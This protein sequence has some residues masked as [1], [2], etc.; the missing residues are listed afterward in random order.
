MQLQLP[1]INFITTDV[2]E[3]VNDSIKMYESLSGRKLGEAD[4]MRLILL[5]HAYIIVQQNIKINEAARQNLLYYATGNVLE[6]KGTEWAT[7]KL[8]ATAA[9]TILRV[10]FPQ[11]LKTA[12]IIVKGTLVTAD[13]SLFFETIE[14]TTCPVDAVSID[15]PIR[16]TQTG[17]IGNG[18]NEGMI[19]TLVKPLSFVEKVENIAVSSGGAEEE[20]DDE[21]RARIYQ[22]PEQ[23]SVAGPTG[24][25]EYHAKKA[26][27]LIADVKV[28]SPEPGV[29]NVSVIEEGGRLPSEAVLEAVTA[30]LNV[31]SVRPLT[32]FVVVKAPEQKEY[33]LDVT[34][35]IDVL[36]ND[37][38]L[39]QQKIEKA[40]D[41]Y[42]VWQSS[43]IGRDINP[44]QL[45]AN[46]IAAG[47]KRVDVLSPS[48]AAVT[49]DEV[50]VLTTRNV[51]FG[52]EE[53]A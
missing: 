38:T 29:V 6:H 49:D 10:Y 45:I 18:Y 11:P 24:A 52:G 31:R 33:A 16:C 42:V 35:Y 22:A 13:G 1:E 17:T 12:Q 40:I 5:S 27:V 3:I 23:L 19:K 51:V 39:I 50:A 32:D 25:Y 37:K 9:T 36:S 15:V 20:A 8:A 28:K 21:Y 26:S 7:P 47:A 14:E 46:C 2:N 4:P 34:Y 41:E 53:H 48:Y 44:S 43:K 30:A